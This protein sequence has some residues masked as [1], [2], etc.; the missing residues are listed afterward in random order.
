MIS[1]HNSSTSGMYNFSCHVMHPSSRVTTPCCFWAMA[2]CTSSSVLDEVFSLT[3]SY[4]C[5]SDSVMLTS[6][7][8]IQNCNSWKRWGLK[9]VMLT[10]SFSLLHKARM[11]SW[12]IMAME[13]KFTCRLQKKQEDLNHHLIHLQQ[14]LAH[15]PSHLHP[16]LPNT[17][18]L[19]HEKAV[20]CF[21]LE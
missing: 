11:V 3:W 13:A 19:L 17:S 4:Y 20:N 10:L 12:K 16:N 1:S 9:T 7:W 5:V 18:Q 14:C 21:L 8:F 15:L 2:F 6:L